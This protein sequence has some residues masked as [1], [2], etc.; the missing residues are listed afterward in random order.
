MH[1][2]NCSSVSSA[3]SSSSSLLAVNDRGSSAFDDVSVGSH[4][5]AHHDVAHS[6]SVK[7]ITHG[8]TAEPWVNGGASPL[9]WDDYVRSKNHGGGR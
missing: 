3:A 7:V 9:R 4:D 2:S 1:Q 5:Q 8:E 6:S